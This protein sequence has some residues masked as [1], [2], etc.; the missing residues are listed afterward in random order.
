MEAYVSTGF[1]CGDRGQIS[2]RGETFAA[3]ALGGDVRIPEHE[4]GAEPLLRE[5]DLS[6]VDQGQAGLIDDH[7]DSAR[8]EH[9]ILR[10]DGVGQVDDVGEARTSGLAYPETQTER[11][12]IFTQEAADAEK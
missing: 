1:F 2:G 7:L 10:T 5:V 8:L 3:T 4:L 9:L 12:G 6:A 11:V